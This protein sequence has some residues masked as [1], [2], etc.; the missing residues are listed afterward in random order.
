MLQPCVLEESKRVT[1]VSCS[2]RRQFICCPLDAEHLHTVGIVRDHSQITKF[3]FLGERHTPYMIPT[4]F[5]DSLI[6]SAFIKK[7]TCLSGILLLCGICV[8]WMQVF[9]A[10]CFQIALSV[11]EISCSWF[12]VGHAYFFLV[13]HQPCVSRGKHSLCLMTTIYFATSQ[14]IAII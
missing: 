6:S 3:S 1:P 4:A 2:S 9:L 14:S 12:L 10:F 7:E 5:R 11:V 13:L 8:F